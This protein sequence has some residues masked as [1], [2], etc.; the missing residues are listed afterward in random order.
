VDSAAKTAALNHG[1]FRRR[2]AL[3]TWQLLEG[4]VMKIP[5]G[6]RI[7]LIVFSLEAALLIGAGLIF[8]VLIPHWG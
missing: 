6:I 1:F 5:E 3:A 2:R 4:S 7:P 8:L